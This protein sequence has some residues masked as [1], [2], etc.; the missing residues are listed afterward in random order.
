MR[1]PVCIFAGSARCDHTAVVPGS[2]LLVL[3]VRNKADTIGFI[4]APRPVARQERLIK[5]DPQPRIDAVFSVQIAFRTMEIE[6][7]F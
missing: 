1:D 5:K 7:L 6:T 4:A 3:S 2:M